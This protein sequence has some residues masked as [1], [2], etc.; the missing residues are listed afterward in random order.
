MHP[1]TVTILVMLIFI[2]MCSML[3]DILYENIEV[4]RLL[5]EKEE[6]R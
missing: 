1:C 2:L 6:L 3:Y 4:V 5:Y